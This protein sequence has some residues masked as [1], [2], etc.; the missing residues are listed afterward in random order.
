MRWT[1]NQRL[2]DSLNLPGRQAVGTIPIG[3]RSDVLKCQGTCEY[4]VI[5]RQHDDRVESRGD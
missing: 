2:A 1:N 3:W 5:I 4:F